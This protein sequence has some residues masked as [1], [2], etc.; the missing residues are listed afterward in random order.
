MANDLKKNF[1]PD[2]TPTPSK[3]SFNLDL[4]DDAAAAA[5]AEAA[6]RR[7][8]QQVAESAT[9]KIEADAKE[10]EELVQSSPEKVAA[11]EEVR[12][13]RKTAIKRKQDTRDLVGNI[14]AWT[15]T[16]LVLIVFLYQQLKHG[17]N[18]AEPYISVPKLPMAGTYV[19]VTEAKSGWKKRGTE[20]RTTAV[21][22]LLTRK[23]QYPL[24]LPAIVLKVT[25]SNAGKTAFLRVLFIDPTG[26]IAG[27]PRLVRVENGKV[28]PATTTSTAEKILGDDRVQITGSAGFVDDY[29]LD[30]YMLSNGRRWSVE[31]SESDNY[32]ARG[33]QWKVIQTFAISN[34][35]LKE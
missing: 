33:D 9:A 2:P 32:Q 28:T 3:P 24:F 1:K 4:E 29:F 6:K 7:E 34:E 20:D 13:N 5:Y 23:S 19:Q 10:A 21:P 17:G 11:M 14:I 25:A 27:D 26:K 8:V 12:E 15:V 22:E 18:A 31:V 16:P 30:D 35:K